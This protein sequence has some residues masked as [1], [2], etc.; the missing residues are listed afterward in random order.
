MFLLLLVMRHWV[1]STCSTSLVPMP[2]ARAPS[3]AVSR[4]AAVAADDRSTGE[5]EALLRT[6]DMND[7]LPLAA[8]AKA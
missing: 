5:G 6:N 2:K 8:E 4:R 1:A 7:T 3:G